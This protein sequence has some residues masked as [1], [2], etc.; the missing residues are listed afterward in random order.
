MKFLLFCLL[1]TLTFSLKVKHEETQKTHT[2]KFIGAN[3]KDGKYST[4]EILLQSDEVVH[5]IA[6]HEDEKLKK[7][8][9]TVIVEKMPQFLEH[10]GLKKIN[11]KKKKQP[12]QTKSL[13][14]LDQTK[15]Q[16][17]HN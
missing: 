16:S 8:E 13:K 12:K 14:S 15:K 7:S 17:E 2:I 11:S 9:S 3:P 4:C 5:R 1:V 6:N 10:G